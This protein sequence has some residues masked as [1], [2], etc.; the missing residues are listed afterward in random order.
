VWLTGCRNGGDA[1]QLVGSVERTI[2]ARGAGL[3]VSA[4][5]SKAQ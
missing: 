2:A 4:A 5:G 1:L 3:Q